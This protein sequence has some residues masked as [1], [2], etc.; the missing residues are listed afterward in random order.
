VR[1]KNTLKF[2]HHNLKK[3][4]PIA[5]SFGKNISDTSNDCFV[6]HLIH[7]LFL[8]YLGKENEQNIA[9]LTTLVLLLNQNNTKHTFCPYFHR[10]S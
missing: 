9:F 7:C 3:S 10:F 2:L 5:I 8:H 6:F 4:D 1:H